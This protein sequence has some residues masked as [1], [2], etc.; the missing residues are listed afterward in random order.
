MVGTTHLPTKLKEP[1]RRARMLP[2][3][4]FSLSLRE[5]S[6]TLATRHF[7]LSPAS[8]SARH[9]LPSSSSSYFRGRAET[10]SNV[11][12]TVLL[13]GSR[14][15]RGVP[16]PRDETFSEMKRIGIR[17]SDTSRKTRATINLVRSADLSPR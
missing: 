14:R 5:N 3:S 1:F 10:F 9:L 12:S 4:E 13:Y 2:S 8:P 17:M 6:T 11:T 15:L 7:S 16:T